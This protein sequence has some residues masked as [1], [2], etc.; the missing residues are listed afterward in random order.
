MTY[1]IELFDHEEDAK[2]Q[3]S[4]DIESEQLPVALVQAMSMHNNAKVATIYI[5]AD[6]NEAWL[7]D[8]TVDGDG[9]KAFSIVGNSA[10]NHELEAIQA[11]HRW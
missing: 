1:H 7:H 11:E 9:I 2:P 4:T 6:D 8:V 3:F 10:I 5:N